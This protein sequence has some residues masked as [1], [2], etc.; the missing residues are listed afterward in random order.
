MTKQLCDSFKVEDSKEYA[1]CRARLIDTFV[2]IDVSRLRNRTGKYINGDT[3]SVE[4]LALCALVAPIVLPPLYCQGIFQE[5][6]AALEASDTDLQA[7]LA[8]FRATPVGK[9]CLNIY[10]EIRNVEN[11]LTEL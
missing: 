5:Q 10:D 1:E 11:V 9:Y 7:E 2:E 8:F 3:V 6:F 4:D